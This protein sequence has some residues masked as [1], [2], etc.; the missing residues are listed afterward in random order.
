MTTVSTTEEVRYLVAWT[1]NNVLIRWPCV[2]C[3]EDTEKQEVLA[4]AYAG[5]QS[6]EN[7]IGMVCDACVDGGAAGMGARLTRQAEQLE[8]RAAKVRREAAA[9]W[10]F[11]SAEQTRYLHRQDWDGH[12]PRPSVLFDGSDPVTPS[13]LMPANFLGPGNPPDGICVFWCLRCAGMTAPKL[14]TAATQ[15]GGSEDRG[16]LDTGLAG[17]QRT[18]APTTTEWPAQRVGDSHLRP[19]TDT[20][21]LSRAHLYAHGDCGGECEGPY[22]KPIGICT[23]YVFPI[24]EGLVTITAGPEPPEKGGNWVEVDLSQAEARRLAQLLLVASDDAGDLT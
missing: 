2:I 4:I 5:S 8:A 15:D 13:D 17:E 16:Q 18:P 7:E 12:D 1:P 10:Q 22:P 19:M 20:V 21:S 3:G 24:D 14:H 23:L 9:S 11:P 6:Y